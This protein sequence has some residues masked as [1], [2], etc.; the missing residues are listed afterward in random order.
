EWAC[1]MLRLGI[2]MYGLYPSAEVNKQRIALEPV[3]SL[4]TEVVHVKTTPAGWGISYGTRYVTEG[5]ELIG[6][7]PVG[8]ADGFSRMLSGKANGLVRGVKSPIR[9]TICMDQ[10]MIA[11]DPAG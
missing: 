10:C 1:G 8:Y 3:M 6:T 5:E 2:S 9:G 4:K 7:I 11:L